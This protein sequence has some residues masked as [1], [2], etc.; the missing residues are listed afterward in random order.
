LPREAEPE[1]PMNWVDGI[2]RALAL[3]VPGVLAAVFSVKQGT[4]EQM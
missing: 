2:K 3:D 4:E 1:I